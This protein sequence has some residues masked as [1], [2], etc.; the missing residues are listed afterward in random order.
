[1]RPRISLEKVALIVLVIEGFG[2]LSLAQ[3][4]EG[5]PMQEQTFPSETIR[6]PAVAGTWYSNNAEVLAREIDH[7]LDQASNANL[8]RDPIALVSPHAG[9]AYSGPTAAWAY[10]QVKDI[11]YESVIVIAPSHQEWFDGVSVWDR[12]AY[13]TPLGLIPVDVDLAKKIEDADKDVH[14]TKAG[15]GAEHALEIELPFL[16]RTVPNLKIVPL[17]MA[18][19]SLGTCRKL[20]NAIQ[21]AVGTQKVLIVASSDLYHGYNY[22]ECIRTDNN[23][24]ERIEHLD[25]ETLCNGLESKKYMACGGG[26][27]TV[28]I[29]A[30][31]LMGATKAQILKHTNSNDVIGERGGYVVGYG[32]VAIY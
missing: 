26:P 27:I 24:L 1:M 16:Q 9:Y 19:R 14:F 5:E 22:D 30:A 13:Q 3:L 15:H 4:P 6:R 10:R 8:P 20:A 18:D 2:V 21:K 17:V 25:A 31:K 29:M 32:A 12:G 28:A 7:Y 11:P 23:T